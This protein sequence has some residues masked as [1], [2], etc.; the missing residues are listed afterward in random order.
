MKSLR[1][2]SLNVGENFSDISLFIQNLQFL[3]FGGGEEEIFRAK[4]KGQRLGIG[5]REAVVIGKS[6]RRRR[7]FLPLF[8]F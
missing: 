3:N 7:C 5:I 2:P 1:S 4:T 8:D 6:E